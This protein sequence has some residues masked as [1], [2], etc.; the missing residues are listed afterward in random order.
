[1]SSPQTE[2]QPGNQPQPADQQSASPP[3]ELTNK[4]QKPTYW[5]RAKQKIQNGWYSFVDKMEHND[6]AVVAISTMVTALFTALLVAATAFLFISSEKVA[7]AAKQSA[8][9]AK[10][11]VK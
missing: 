1:M 3:P 7:D 10:D 2:R 8:D 6:K 9:A 4:G 11:A 5:S